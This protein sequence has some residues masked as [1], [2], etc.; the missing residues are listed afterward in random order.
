MNMMRNA[1]AY[2][3]TT[4]ICQLGIRSVRL[5][6]RSSN[7][8]NSQIDRMANNPISTSIAASQPSCC[9]DL[10]ISLAKDETAERYPQ[11]ETGQ[12]Y[13]ERV[14]RGVHVEHQHPR[15]QHFVRQRTGARHPVHTQNNEVHI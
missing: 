3:A 6:I 9:F 15:P 5:I 12:H 4:N 10:S 14:G 1:P 11:Q 2:L 8:L 13:R 7:V